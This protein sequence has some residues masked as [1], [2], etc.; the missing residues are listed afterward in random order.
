VQG[1]LEA[2]SRLELT[3]GVRYDWYSDI[4]QSVNPR[5]AIV[6]A[7]PFQ[8]S[9]KVMYGRAFRAP[10][11]VELFEQPVQSVP[12]GDPNNQ[13]EIVNTVEAGYVQHI[14]DYAQATLTY[15]HNHVTEVMQMTDALHG[16]P[17]HNGGEST[18]QGLE[19]EL[20]T[21]DVYGVNLL[22]CYTHL[23]ATKAEQQQ[24]SYF[25]MPI[26]FGAASLTYSWK[27]LTVNFNSIL[28]GKAR[29]MINSIVMKSFT[30]QPAYALVNAHVQLEVV[31]G[32]RPYLLVENI[33]DW[34]YHGPNV[35]TVS[36]DALFRGRTFMLG[37]RADI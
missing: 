36:Q 34:Q 35:P 19:F 9:L 25:T 17:F 6:F 33:F 23:F 30:E 2:W 24:D 7:T 14:L 37:V 12:I 3:A 21:R 8:S 18:V 31:N 26:D 27:Q 16:L 32:V 1:K 10:S 15:F 28:R 29:D 5:A 13:A 11:W 4:G 22:G 20:R